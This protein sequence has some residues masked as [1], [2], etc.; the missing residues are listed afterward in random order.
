M[1]GR[2]RAA[3]R[4]TMLLIF[5]TF[6]FH[7]S[8][9]FIYLYSREVTKERHGVTQLGLVLLN[10]SVHRCRRFRSHREILTTHQGVVQKPRRRRVLSVKIMEYSAVMEAVE[11]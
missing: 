8:Y 11:R 10:F 6:L 5:S 3:S 9:L 4:V 7:F 2:R 1:K